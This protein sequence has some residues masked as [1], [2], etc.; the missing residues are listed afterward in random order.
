M[1][2]LFQARD[3]GRTEWL[4]GSGID[5]PDQTGENGKFLQTDGTVTSWEDVADVDHGIPVGG[6]TGQVL[7]KTSNADYAADWADEPAPFTL[8]VDN[9]GVSVLN[10]ATTLNFI[11]PGVVASDSGGG[12]AEVNIPGGSSAGA[13]VVRKFPF[14]FDTADILTGH[15]VYVP[16]IGDLLLDAWVEIDT[17]WDGTTP[18]FDFGT[19][20]GA[21][22]GIYGG[23][24]APVAL[25]SQDN[26]TGIGA[27]YLYSHTNPN[28]DLQTLGVPTLGV[29]RVA[30]GK[31][32]AA[33][34]LKI[35]VSQDGTNVGA[36][37]GS[38]QGAAILYLVTCTPV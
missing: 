38:T 33:N 30:P 23:A 10:G 6:T 25:G 11:G 34:P 5:L 12:I 32:I 16:T 37:P 7:A 26:D 27:G 8:N 22:N 21:T 31:F 28:N 35:V 24:N 15:T 3:G 17:A 36:D 20:V 14:A 9:Q 2:K 1:A 13:P 18:L 19:F 4:E 29:S